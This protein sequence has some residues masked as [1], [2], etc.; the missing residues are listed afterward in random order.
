MSNLNRERYRRNKSLARQFHLF[1][2]LGGIEAQDLSKQRQNCILRSGKLM[3]NEQ[4]RSSVSKVM[5]R[6]SRGYGGSLAMVPWNLVMC[7]L[8]LAKIITMAMVA[9]T[10]AVHDF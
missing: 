4:I 9:L 3:I 7:P 8:T 10:S 6:A 2:L 1:N 5:N